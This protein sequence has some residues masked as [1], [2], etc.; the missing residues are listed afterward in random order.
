MCLEN[1]YK[2]KTLGIYV[3]CAFDNN[4]NGSQPTDKNPYF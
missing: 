1:V 4:N 3:I 2:I